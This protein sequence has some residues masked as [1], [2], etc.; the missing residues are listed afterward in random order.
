MTTQ[1]GRQFATDIEN[2]SL[3]YSTV[4]R[5]KFVMLNPPKNFSLVNDYGTAEC[6]ILI[7]DFKVDK[8]EKNILIGKLIDN[9]KIYI[10]D[11]NFNRVPIGVVGELIVASIHVGADY[12]NRPEK[13]AE[14]FINCNGM[15]VYKSSD[16]ARWTAN[17]DVEI[18]GR[19]D[20][21]IKLRGSSQTFLNEQ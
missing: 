9:V 20:N 16:Y 14:R 5:E 13:T 3:K 21:Q 4:G 10:V 12:L 19:L 11:Q 7:T 15:R 2:H 17:G 8:S 1:V 18:S 6:I